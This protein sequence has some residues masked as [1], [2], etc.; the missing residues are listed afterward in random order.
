MNKRYIFLSLTLLLA[1][2]LTSSVTFGL[3]ETTH[4]WPMHRHDPARTGTTAS[5]APNTN[6][7]LWIHETV[8][9]FG[10]IHSTIIADGKLIFVDYNTIK[11]LDETTGVE[12]W[13]SIAFPNFLG[14]ELAYADDKIYV[15]S[16][17]GYLYCINASTG[18]KLWEYNHGTG[19]IKSGPSVVDG[20]VYFGTTDNYLYAINASNSLYIWRYTA[21]G[22][23]YSSPTISED[24]L[25]FGCD[26]G[27]V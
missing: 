12:L 11:A 3:Y 7:T 19:S 4:P 14:S 21:P 27:K 24:L 20:R 13:S 16:D 5:T 15:G 26:D 9:S 6:N 22:P 1:F 25:Y 17:G 10:N 18:A 23:I 2:A 8:Y